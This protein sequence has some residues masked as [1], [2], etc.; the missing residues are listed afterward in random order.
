MT[1]P[2]II[3]SGGNSQQAKTNAVNI[4]LMSFNHE[5]ENG[6]TKYGNM[7]VDSF[8]D[9]NGVDFKQGGSLNGN[10]L[11]F[12]INDVFAK[13]T[14]QYGDSWGGWS[15]Y[16]MGKTITTATVNIYGWSSKQGQRGYGEYQYSVDGTNW[17]GGASHNSYDTTPYYKHTKTLQNFRYIRIRAHGGYYTEYTNNNSWNVNYYGYCKIEV[18]QNHTTDFVVESKAITPTAKFSEI[19][20]VLLQEPIT[21]GAT[22]TVDFSVD[23]GTT[24]QGANVNT[25]F[26]KNSTD[27]V[28]TATAKI[29]GNHQSIIKW[30]L[31]GASG[32]SQKFH[33]IATMWG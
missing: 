8:A 5:T 31:T 26:D 32:K 17:Q 22:F 2:S 20:S 28:Y 25:L 21:N 24:W 30:R 4:A 12:M 1:F 3:S 13:E 15:V 11:N 19:K 33:S 29:K 9:A 18:I 16:D 23:G 7:A 14:S 27:K 6:M 10:K